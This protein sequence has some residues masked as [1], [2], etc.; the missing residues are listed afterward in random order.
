MNTRS[1]AATCLADVQPTIS[2][3]PKSVQDDLF[4]LKQADL[5]EDE[6]WALQRIKTHLKELHGS[7]PCVGTMQAQAAAEEIM[8][9]MSKG[10]GG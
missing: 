6:F 1:Y 7:A 9:R 8:R 10:P 5:S 2:L 3:V 4:K